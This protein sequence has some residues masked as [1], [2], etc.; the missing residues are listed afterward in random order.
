MCS[1]LRVLPQ[2]V[3]KMIIVYGCSDGDVRTT[4][5]VTRLTSCGVASTPEVVIDTATTGCVGATSFFRR[6]LRPCCFWRCNSA[7][8][9][10]A[11]S[12][13]TSSTVTSSS[14]AVT[15]S[16]VTSQSP[17]SDLCAQSVIS[18]EWNRLGK[19]QRIFNFTLFCR[20]SLTLCHL[21]VIT[22]IP[23]SLYINRPVYLFFAVAS[24]ESIQTIHR[25]VY[26]S[27]QN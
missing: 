21:L 5:Y 26:Q 17:S 14:A 10:G 18:V 13:M 6:R 3:V 4:T 23:Q 9:P 25:L 11:E 16:S 24:Y 15:S 19:P 20:I 2:V 22:C 8:P 1:I 12:P 7:A 27:N